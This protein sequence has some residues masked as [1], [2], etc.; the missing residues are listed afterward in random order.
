M[1]HWAK[2]TWPRLASLA[3]RR[4]LERDLDDEVAFHLAMREEKNRAGG[5]AR[6]EASY[7]ARRQFGNTTSVKERALEMWTLTWL[8]DLW[9]DL[10]YGE[11]VLM[12][13]PGFS[14]IAIVTLALGIGASTAIFSV[15]DSVLLRP[16]PYQHPDRLVQVWETNT[17][18][19]YSRNVVNPINFLDWRDQNRAFT[20]MAAIS[21]VA[22][23]LNLGSDPLSAPAIR[24]TPQFF[25]ILGVAPALGRTFTDDD[26]VPGN[27]RKL[28]LSYEFWQ[29]QF[30]GNRS[31][32]NTTVQL[33]D[34]A[35]T[36]V[37]VMPRGF[38]LPNV[39]GSVWLPFALVHSKTF[40]DQ[41][42]YMMV[43][44]RLRS[45]VTLEQAQQDMDRVAHSAA[46]ARPNFN[47]DWG[48]VV[49]PMLSDATREVRTPLLVLLSAVG[50]VLLIACANVANLLL[51]RGTRRGQEIAVRAAL[52]ASRVRLVQQLLVESLLLALAGTLGGLAIGHWG[53]RALLSL[54]PAADAL[55]RMES[56]HMDSSVFLFALA[57]AF[58]TTVL[59]GLI[60]AIRVSRVSLQDTLKQGASRAGAGGNHVLRQS[61]VVAEVALALLLSIG[62]GLLL[63]S[64]QRLTAVNLGFEP[65][66]VVTM[67]V[68]A[69]PVKYRDDQ[70]RSQYL[71]RI[72]SE[73][74]NTPGVQAAG[75]VHF[76]P[77]MD[78]V[79]GSCF[80]IG[81]EPAVNE[82]T[83]PD[84]Q[85]LVVSSGYFGAIGTP[86]QEG[87][88]IGQSDS[89][90]TPSVV[91]VNHSFVKKFFP[92]GNAIGKQLNV[93]WTVPN[94]VR[95][96][97]V[98]ADARQTR[99]KD[100]P[101]PTIFVPNAQAPMY[102]ATLVVRA[103]GDPRQIV[104][105]AEM[106][107]HRVDPDQAIAEVRTMA[108]VFSDSASDA[109]FQLVLLM[110]FAGVAI[111]LA[112][113]G[114]YG[115]VSY[116]VRQRTRE[117]G[118]RLAMGAAASAIA[119]M[120]LRE[121]LL[122]AGLAVAIGLAGALALTRVM[123]GL[124]YETTP[125]DP[126]ILVVV[127]V[128]VLLVAALAAL[129]PARRAVGIDPM[130]ALRHQ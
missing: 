56:I 75:S 118:I 90:G 37:G 9:K 54:I 65:D 87:R 42:R 11:R 93:C 55:P 86:L 79:S 116:S 105:G 19:G 92:D 43:V 84:S 39:K 125:T 53:L 110:I 98:V 108:R 15:V 18:Q 40:A 127:S 51:M 121:A 31:V 10:H 117:I 78:R 46:E 48:A 107:V 24:V 113:T 23:N 13:N 100:P 72:V 59:F 14:A 71:Q 126:A 111:V 16:L 64:F 96:V 49:L 4:Q 106:A 30:G 44:A 101:A 66:R 50:F 17:K 73:I 12:K 124:L 58:L 25:S 99:L 8:E 95:I 122:L 120:V 21:D 20:S 60:P 85:F 81:A 61:L 103:K 129:V 1:L 35:A 45:G 3:K 47:T 74:R 22:V 112:V 63:R 7:A 109:R 68:F 41:G 94:P 82:S 123:Q 26:G 70:K 97:G 28:I 119:G 34:V 36:V 6:P 102:M 38:G 91:V 69:S 76:L 5:I 29:Q 52:G 114:V 33:N 130:A 2:K 67:R 115:V 83:A 80:A 89:F 88:D 27:D 57:L 104:Q 77:L 62:A 128:A 32:L